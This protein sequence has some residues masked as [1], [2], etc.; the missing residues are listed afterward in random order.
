MAE[1][2]TTSSS[3]IS[4]LDSAIFDEDYDDTEP[5]DT[6]SSTRLLTPNPDRAFSSNR[7]KKGPAIRRKL[8]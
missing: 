8:T 7:V 5:L 2:N 6:S 3:D 1:S 4:N